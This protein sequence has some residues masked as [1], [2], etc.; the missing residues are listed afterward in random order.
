MFVCQGI[1]DWQMPNNKILAV[2]ETRLVLTSS[3]IAENAASAV[4]VMGCAP[5]YAA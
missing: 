3:K 4:L 1:F 5:G 2:K